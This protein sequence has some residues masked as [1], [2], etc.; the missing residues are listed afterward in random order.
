M[1]EDGS[2]G[3][4]DLKVAENPATGDIL[5]MTTPG[6][7]EVVLITDA[8][9]PARFAYLQLYIGMKPADTHSDVPPGTYPYRVDGE[10][11]RLVDFDAERARFKEYIS[12]ELAGEEDKAQSRRFEF[13]LEHLEETAREAAAIPHVDH[14]LA[15]GAQLYHLDGQAA[16]REVQGSC[17]ECGNA[18]WV[19]P[20]CG[21]FSQTF[22]DLFM[23]CGVDLACPQC[24]GW[25][26]ARE[27]KIYHEKY[28]LNK[29]PPEIFQERER[30][31]R[32]RCEELGYSTSQP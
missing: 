10:E 19:C 22:P 6:R 11:V 4:P 29:P 28:Y 15:A 2:L 20:G 7:R 8:G 26:F 30:R 32:E 17:W 31:L 3:E 18:R 27:D 16:I 14:T 9:P 5:L 23:G 1:V 24:L 21:G 13:Q 12:A 25:E